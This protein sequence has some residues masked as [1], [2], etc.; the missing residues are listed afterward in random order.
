MTAG[1]IRT[2]RSMFIARFVVLN[3]FPNAIAKQKISSDHGSFVFSTVDG[4]A[5]PFA[6]GC[7]A[8]PRRAVSFGGRRSDSFVSE[9]VKK[10]THHHGAVL[11]GGW[12][13]DCFIVE[14]V[15]NITNV[16]AGV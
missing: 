7:V 6:R 1:F 11:F 9:L 13:V 15:K 4:P 2:L 16:H 3:L 10:I 5:R 12:A 14:L 8:T